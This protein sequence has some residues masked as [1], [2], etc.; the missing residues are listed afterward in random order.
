MLSYPV[1]K[2]WCGE[3]EAGQSASFCHARCFLCD[4]LCE[5]LRRR[6]ATIRQRSHITD[7]QTKDSLVHSCVMH[8]LYIVENIILNLLFVAEFKRFHLSNFTS[9]F[10]VCTHININEKSTMTI[11]LQLTLT[12]RNATVEEVR[13]GQ[14]GFSRE[15]L[16][17]PASW[18]CCQLFF[19][20]TAPVL[21]L[22]YISS[23]TLTYKV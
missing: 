4:W 9:W 1:W 23:N 8:L 18:H 12:W 15:D 16:H 17:K 14:P 11:V 20:S 19:S 10:I 5:R 21:F 6:E 2:C 13:C 3:A 7:G 22:F